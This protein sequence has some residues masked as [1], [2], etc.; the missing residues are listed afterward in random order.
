MLYSNILET[1]G[2]D[3]LRLSKALA[4]EEGIFVGICGGAT[5]AGGHDRGRTGDRPF[6]TGRPFRCTATGAARRRQ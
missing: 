4:Q 5:L 3:A 6:D 1:V 2:N